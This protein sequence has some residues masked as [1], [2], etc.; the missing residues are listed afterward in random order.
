MPVVPLVFLIVN[1]SHISQIISHKQGA[2]SWLA[3]RCYYVN[4]CSFTFHLFTEKNKCEN[5]YQHLPFI[6]QCCKGFPAKSEVVALTLSHTFGRMYCIVYFALCTALILEQY[7]FKSLYSFK[8]YTTNMIKTSLQFSWIM[9]AD[10][11]LKR[12][13]Y[14]HIFFVHISEPRQENGRSTGTKEWTEQWMEKGMSGGGYMA[15]YKQKTWR[16]NQEC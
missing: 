2:C 13:I 8:S 7:S 5:L 10:I 6:T 4:I 14:V 3:P 1:Y 9:A 16:K 15:T 12:W 11:N